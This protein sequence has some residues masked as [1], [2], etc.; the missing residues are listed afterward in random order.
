[1]IVFQV[2]KVSKYSADKE[3]LREV[4]LAVQEKTGFSA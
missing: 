1:M 2:Q 3:V 4:S